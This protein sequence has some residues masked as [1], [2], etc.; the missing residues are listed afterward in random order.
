MFITWFNAGL[1]VFDISRPSLP[2]EV[3]YF[4]PPE[5]AGLPE[6]SGPHNSPRKSQSTRAAI[7]I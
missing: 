7:S 2:T 6:Q 1:R 3:G 4:M 5:R